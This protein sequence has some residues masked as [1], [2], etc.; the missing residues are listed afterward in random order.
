MRKEFYKSGVDAIRNITVGWQ[1]YL[2][3]GGSMD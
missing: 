3:L 1:I 2:L